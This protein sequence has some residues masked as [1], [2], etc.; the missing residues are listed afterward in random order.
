MVEEAIRKSKKYQ[1]RMQLWK[2]LPR[3]VQYQTFQTI[4]EYLEDSNKILF[5]DHG[6]IIWIAIDDSKL[7][8]LLES[9]VELH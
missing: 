6:H 1:T 7:K 2:S 5:D 8:A 3:K 9:G 4:L